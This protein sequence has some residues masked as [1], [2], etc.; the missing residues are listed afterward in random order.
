[1]KSAFISISRQGA[2][3]FTTNVNRNSSLMTEMKPTLENCF[4]LS[5]NIFCLLTKFN[6]FYADTMSCSFSWHPNSGL[7]VSSHLLQ[8]RKQVPCFT[9]SYK[10]H[11]EKKLPG[12]FTCLQIPLK[13]LSI[14]ITPSC[15]TSSIKLTRGH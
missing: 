4:K 3:N 8:L 10:R 9:P 6:D 13:L 12:L 7:H 14:D 2:K 1:M 15:I 11:P 5:Q